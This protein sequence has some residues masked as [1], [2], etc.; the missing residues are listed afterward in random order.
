TVLTLSSA[1]T[2]SGGTSIDGG[3]INFSS[4]TSLGTGTVFLGSQFGGGGDAS[5]YST[6]GVTLA[7]NI[8]VEAGNGILTLGSTFFNGV[9]T[10]TYSGTITLLGDLRISSPG[11]LTLSGPIT[12]T[13]NGLGATLSLLSSDALFSGMISDGFG[14]VI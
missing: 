5:L 10:P 13:G 3:T 12:G 9:N 2:Y 1:N 7:N 6:A 14:G 8:M 4:A 11:A